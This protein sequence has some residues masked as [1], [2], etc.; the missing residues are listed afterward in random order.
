MS[1]RRFLVILMSQSGKF[2]LSNFAQLTS[3]MLLW[4]Y[5]EFQLLE[6]LFFNCPKLKFQEEEDENHVEVEKNGDEEEFG[7]EIEAKKDEEV[8]KMTMKFI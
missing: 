2:F 3:Q 5:M 7:E 4:L 1:S 6:K 8:M